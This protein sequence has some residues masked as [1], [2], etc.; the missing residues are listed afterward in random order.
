MELPN[1][2]FTG[3]SN[4]YPF[5]GKIEFSATFCTMFDALLAPFN[6]EKIAKEVLI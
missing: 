6:G 1:G 4:Y 3:I 5:V 2:G